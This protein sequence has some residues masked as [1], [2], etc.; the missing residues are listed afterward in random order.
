MTH[1][2]TEHGLGVRSS[3]RSWTP[4]ASALLLAT[5]TACGGSSGSSSG[6]GGDVPNDGHVAL[7][8]VTPAR[9]STSGGTRVTLYGE[10]FTLGL[11]GP[12]EVRFGELQAAEV[13]VLND[14]TLTAVA[15]EGLAGE[16]VQV[17]VGNSAGR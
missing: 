8:G 12:N 10:G 1:R 16:S 13:Q 15:P 17:T 9:G 3:Q 4:W 7:P 5:L 11:D 2:S 14:Q 6:G